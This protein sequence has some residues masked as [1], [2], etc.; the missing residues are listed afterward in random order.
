MRSD[1]GSLA[2]AIIYQVGAI[3]TWVFLTFFDGKGYEEWWQW[4]IAAG[5]NAAISE[6]W[7]VYWIVFRPIMW[8]FGW[9]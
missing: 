3:A 8:A 4:V 9:L 1:W 5:L 2:F 7:P 6:F